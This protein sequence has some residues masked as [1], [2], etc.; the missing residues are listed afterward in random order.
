MSL[1]TII[2]DIKE[3]DIMPN[4]GN[5]CIEYENN[6]YKLGPGDLVHEGNVVASVDELENG[7]Y[8]FILFV[9]S[10]FR[11]RSFTRAFT[12]TFTVGAYETDLNDLS[13]A[14][15]LVNACCQ[16][17][18]AACDR[19]IPYLRI[20]VAKCHTLWE[21]GTKHSSIV[22]GSLTKNDFIISAG[23]MMKTDDSAVVNAF[24]GT[25]AVPVLEKLAASINIDSN[26]TKL[27]LVNSLY[28]N[29]VV[30]LLNAISNNTRINPTSDVL[31]TKENTMPYVRDRLTH[32][33]ESGRPIYRFNTSAECNRNV[34]LEKIRITVRI[35]QLIAKRSLLQRRFRTI[36]TTD[37]DNQITQL[38]AEG[39]ELDRN[40]GQNVW[41]GNI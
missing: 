41:D 40:L 27:R 13:V 6:Y 11:T 17:E 34:A 20:G 4:T 30:V 14:Q 19:L 33:F 23:E 22:L 28:L 10:S 29:C 15:H 37:I 39:R 18:K 24:S 16:N 21:N 7:L 25:Y 5:P 3:L 35:R 1:S 9:D 26:T 36:D 12:K 32:F 31:I 2:T 38:E 8:T